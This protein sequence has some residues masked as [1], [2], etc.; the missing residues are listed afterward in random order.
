MTKLPSRT[1][2]T[3]EAVRSFIPVY[4]P[5]IGSLEK[6]Y[7]ND[8]LDT[9]WISSIGKYVERFESEIAAIT[10]SK[11]AVA[12]TNGTVALHL[13]H[14][15]LGLQPGD[16]IIV[17]TFTYVASVNT[18]A[19][20]GAK[21]VFVECRNSD[22]LLDPDD[23]RAKITPRT[24]GIVPVHLYGAVC[25]MSEIMA[26]AKEHELYVVEDCAESLGSTIDGKPAG[27]FGHCATFSFFGNKTITTGEGGMVTTNDDE[28]AEHL[29]LSKGQGQDP[30]RRYWHDRVGF[31]YRLT[32]IAA[33][34]GCAQLVRL[35][36][37]LVR[38]A[39]IAA[40]YRK[41]LS[42]Q[43]VEFQKIAAN[44]VSSN[45][46]F[47]LLLPEGADREVIMATMKDRGVDTRP[48]FHCSHTMPMYFD[49]DAPS[50]P[51]SEKISARGINLPSYPTMTDEMVARVCE[52]LI[53]AIHR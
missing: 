32:N 45:W 22:W 16:E 35:S 38:K 46:M 39:E 44:V 26:I 25:A 1:S 12:V 33:A 13:A 2:E 24:K 18:I 36:D 34:I 5:S 15:C 51:V 53:D 23:V 37:I 10:N 50:F 9:S 47:S 48:V 20:T 49:R 52:T 42:N 3:A 17:P 14:H 6:E 11:Y 21:P 30:N 29:R 7:V 28:L 4:E 8:C 43:P 41:L 40:L 27:S 19:Q 31:N